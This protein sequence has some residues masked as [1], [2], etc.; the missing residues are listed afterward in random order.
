M[1]AFARAFAVSSDSILVRDRLRVES[2]VLFG[3][4]STN[5]EM[6]SAERLQFDNSKVVNVLILR[7]D[8]RTLLPSQDAGGRW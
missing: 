6:S 1:R 2:E 4:K 7:S 5:E 3:R 8:G